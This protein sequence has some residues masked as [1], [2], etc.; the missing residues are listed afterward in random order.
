M[1]SLEP[2]NV[3]AD[4]FANAEAQLAACQTGS[5]TRVSQV[6]AARLESEFTSILLEQLNEVMRCAP[7]AFRDAITVR[8][9][10]PELHTCSHNREQQTRCD[11]FSCL[12]VGLASEHV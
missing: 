3:E 7:S 9:Q 1:T 8:S 4:L 11:L 5:A 10:L 2:S 6:D 12:L